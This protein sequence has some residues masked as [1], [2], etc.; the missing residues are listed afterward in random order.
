MINTGLGKGQSA[1]TEI[2]ESSWGRAGAEG[3]R[4]RDG[5]GSFAIRRPRM[6]ASRR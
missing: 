2:E 5:I 6:S 3:E 4:L 1:E